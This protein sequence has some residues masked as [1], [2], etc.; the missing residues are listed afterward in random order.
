MYICI[1]MVV[2]FHVL[3]AG[4]VQ[5]AFRSVLAQPQ[6]SQ[7]TMVGRPVLRRPAAA[8]GPVLRRP[9]AAAASGLVLRRPAAGTSPAGDPPSLQHQ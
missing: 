1:P 7:A 8:G 5:C 2:E 9:A 4:M 3:C 6:P